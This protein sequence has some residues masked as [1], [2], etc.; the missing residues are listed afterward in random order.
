[1]II[2]WCLKGV[3]FDQ[4]HFNDG[5]VQAILGGEGITSAWLRNATSPLTNLPAGSQGVLSDTALDD[6]VHNW[7][8]VWHSTP[9]ISLSAGCVERVARGVTV[10]H[11]AMRTA[12]TFATNNATHAGY[13]FLCWVQVSPKPAAEL[14]GFGEEVRNL[15]IY[16]VVSRE[17]V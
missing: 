4:S 15:N 12:L 17:V 5:V 11:S 2:Q 6:H 1:M 8:A 9:Y 14:P 13:V 3:P 7:G 10:R 16:R